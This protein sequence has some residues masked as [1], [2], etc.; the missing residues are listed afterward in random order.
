[1]IIKK[2]IFKGGENVAE[3]CKNCGSEKPGIPVSFG[4][5]NVHL[6]DEKTGDIEHQETSIQLTACQECG[7]VKSMFLNFPKTK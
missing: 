4:G 3:K 6:L 5:V 2:L 7:F 1:M